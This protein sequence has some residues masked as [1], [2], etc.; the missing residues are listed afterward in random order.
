MTS[1]PSCE[2]V[3][4]HATTFMTRHVY[5]NGRPVTILIPA[6][7]VMSLISRRRRNILSLSS[8]RMMVSKLFIW[9]TMS[10]LL[11]GLNIL[12]NTSFFALLVYYDTM[13]H[14]LPYKHSS[15]LLSSTNISKATLHLS[16]EP[17]ILLTHNL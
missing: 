8:T 1:V 9:L 10:V 17:K 11:E 6:A 15:L 4:T 13:G 5:K 16:K 14:L 2:I 7:T 3:H 12:H